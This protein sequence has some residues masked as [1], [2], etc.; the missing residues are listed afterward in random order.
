MDL[1]LREPI[2]ISSKLVLDFTGLDMAEVEV[3]MFEFTIFLLDTTIQNDGM[4]ERSVA[5]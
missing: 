3:K 4:R 1:P 2:S 5:V